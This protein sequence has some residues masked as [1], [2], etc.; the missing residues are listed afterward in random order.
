MDGGSGGGGA[1]PNAPERKLQGPLERD[2]R[3]RRGM[4]QESGGLPTA[5]PSPGTVRKKRR[6]SRGSAVLGRRKLFKATNPY[7][8]LKSVRINRVNNYRWFATNFERYFEATCNN[9][10]V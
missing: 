9:E 3:G 7:T 10:S 8:S 5:G 1:T 6:P 4:L 2:S